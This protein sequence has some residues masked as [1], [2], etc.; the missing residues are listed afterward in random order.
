VY[1]GYFGAGIGIMMLAAL[2]LMGLT[3]IHRMNGL[4]NWGSLCMNIVAAGIFA[5]SR[6]VDWPVAAA[7]ALG[8]LLGGYGAS[9]VAQHV[10]QQP[11]RRA[12]TLVGLAAFLW[13][14]LRP[15]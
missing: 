13:L 12:I 8:G 2:G 11:V 1:G 14:L 9:R 6:I 10:G 3:N 7:M 15:K 4:K 5:S